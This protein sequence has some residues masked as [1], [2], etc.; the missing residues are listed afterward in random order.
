M[1]IQPGRVSN[2]ESSK[3]TIISLFSSWG[4]GLIWKSDLVAMHKTACHDSC[5]LALQKCSIGT[6][7]LLKVIHVAH[8]SFHVCDD[9]LDLH[10][11]F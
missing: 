1:V 8:S 10:V 4:L 2:Q 11:C 5:Y 7:F 6:A 9:Y 3:R